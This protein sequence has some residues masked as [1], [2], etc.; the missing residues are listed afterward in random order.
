MSRATV[1]VSLEEWKEMEKKIKSLEKDK[2]ALEDSI[3]E[4]KGVVVTMKI[5]Y[6]DDDS[7]YYSRVPSVKKTSF[8]S[9]NTEYGKIAAE[10]IEG[11]FPALVEA[12]NENIK[13]R[14]EV[15]DLEDKLSAYE[16]VDKSLLELK[17]RIISVLEL[18]ED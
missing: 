6:P 4:K 12:G 13:L 9:D 18:K 2:K 16:F 3:V 14:A 8:F 5:D 1:T 11:L 10:C 7:P 17:N 15:R